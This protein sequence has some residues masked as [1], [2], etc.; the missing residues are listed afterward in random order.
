MSFKIWVQPVTY[1]ID[2]S[3]SGTAANKELSIEV[4]ETSIVYCGDECS[5]TITISPGDTV[6]MS[7]TCFTSPPSTVSLD[8]T[9]VDNG[10][11]VYSNLQKETEDATDNYGDY[12][13]TGNG[14]ITVIADEF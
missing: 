9:V 1:T 13:P 10:T 14:S 11:T 4:N 3:L 5:G 8:V 12:E 2:Y 6:Y 7:T